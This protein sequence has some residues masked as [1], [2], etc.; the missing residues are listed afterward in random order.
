[1]TRPDDVFVHE[2]GLCESSD[3]GP[4]TRVWAFAHVMDGA[5]VGRD[6]NVCD[7]AFI[8]GGAVLGDRVTVKNSVLVWDKVVVEDDVFL[9]PSAVFTNDPNPRTAFKKPPERFLSTRVRRGAT[10]GANATI[11]CGV[12][13][14]EQAFV[15]AGAVVTH[16]VPA[17]A[18]VFGNPARIAGW[19][20]ECGA[21]LDDEMRCT[22]G[23]AYR[24]AGNA[25]GLVP[26][27]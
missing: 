20:C 13:V 19:V 26:R 12:T 8:E 27:R 22:C 25:G 11:V 16:D 24:F 15:G 21:D 5:R 10:I 3:V 23:R 4:G 2:R 14:G 18:L 6:C 1:V 9:G 17:H 7:H